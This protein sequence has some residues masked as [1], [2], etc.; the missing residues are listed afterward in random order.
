[1]TN[2]AKLSQIQEDLN[3]I[4]QKLESGEYDKGSF[5]KLEHD[6]RDLHYDVWLD[7]YRRQHH[8]EQ[9][10]RLRDLFDNIEELIARGEFERADA[11]LVTYR[12]EVELLQ[13]QVW[14]SYHK[15]C[16]GK[17]RLQVD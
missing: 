14:L 1:M 13:H 7:Y 17:I 15:P 11:A 12:M 6:V 5:D 2:L 16:V 4:R 3:Q 8:A 10:E 9:I